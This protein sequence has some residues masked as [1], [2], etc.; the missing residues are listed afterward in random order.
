MLKTIIFDFDGTIADT[1]DTMIS[2][3]NKIGP[4]FGY[5]PIHEKEKVRNEKLQK[6]FK[7]YN[8]SITKI[9]FFLFKALRE[10][11]K[12]IGNVKPQKNIIETIKKLKTNEF[13]L[14]ILTS[15]SEKNVK[16]FLEKNHLTN[17]FDFIHS[18]KNVFG[19]HNSLRHIL[20]SNKIAK[21][22]VI[23]IGDEVRD[24]EAT[25]KVGIPII[26]VCWGFN[27]KE[28]L[29]KQNPEYLADKPGDLI[30]IASRIR[31]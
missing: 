17:I 6:L 25:K 16:I 21:N 11:N 22:E 15:N 24:I 8:I 20:S 27:K 7:E 23:Y 9:P 30:H 5:K 1:L 14:G 3:Y 26:A 18:E 31:Y 28:I 12:K 29:A 19:K 13:N 4:D 10:F 2:I